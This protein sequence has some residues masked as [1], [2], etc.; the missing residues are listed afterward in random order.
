MAEAKRVDFNA[1]PREVRERLI[2]CMQH[3]SYP[4]PLLS[5]VTSQ[6]AAIA[7]WVILALVGGLIVLVPLAADFGRKLQD[8]A[9]IAAYALGVA[10]VLLS[11]LF[12]ARRVML[13]NALPYKPG[14]FLFPMDFIDATDRNLRVVPMSAL[15]DFRGVHQ[16]TNG[17]Y[18][19]T[20]LT[21][22]FEGGIRES[23]VIQ[24][25]D[26]AEEVL[27]QLQNSQRAIR[28]AAQ[29]RDLDTLLR[30]DPF[31]EVRVKDTWGAQAPRDEDVSGPVAKRLPGLLASAAPIL[32]VS[33]V[34]ALVISIPMWHLRNVASDEAMFAN[35]KRLDSSYEY[36]HYVEYGKRHLDE[37]RDDLLPRAALREAKQ[38]G[39]VTALRTF[40]HDYPKS[41]VEKDARDEI[42]ALF[43]K[44]LGDYREQAATQDPKLLPF[45]EKLLAYLEKNETARVEA[46]FESPST[47]ALQKTD[48]LL[49]T[50]L[51][52]ELAGGG[53]I[54][55]VAPHFADK[56]S[57]PRE[58]EIVT[59]LQK[60]FGE[61]F[62][63]DVMAL[64]QGPRIGPD[65]KPLPGQA[66]DSGSSSPKRNPLLDVDYKDPQALAR[67]LAA[68]RTGSSDEEASDPNDD[69][70][71]AA[72][73]T[74]E[75]KYKVAW[76]GD[77]YTEEK[78]DRKFVGI[79]VDFHVAMKIPGESDT[80]EF[81]LAVKPP[82]RFTVNYTQYNDIGDTGPSEGQVYDQMAERAFDQLSERM[83]KVFF[84]PG[85]KAYGPPDPV[86]PGLGEGDEGDAPLPG[87]GGKKP[88]G[89]LGA[90]GRKPNKL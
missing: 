31:F 34:A 49:Q 40:L 39:S 11:G 51:G 55:P 46:R 16:H 41:V 1:L 3:T 4:Y 73:P 52:N 70:T 56:L 7:G 78:G 76:A 63:T 18:T 17:V 38:K 54:I 25:K 43:T 80:V 13:G 87:V 71:K 75:I 89:G 74:L 29:A 2:A 47:E 57:L 65:G 32:G 64:K 90:G 72:P 69:G 84:R 85:S 68:S 36:K 42:H 83:K 19:G 44:E 12:L 37:V 30:M 8:P 33:A 67:A 88:G 58:R 24:G 10:V 21:F 28:E 53:H 59:G 79:V 81:D 60:G 62:P 86:E 26:R 20:T 66:A 23:F 14:R 45:M 61:V 27:R 22:T 6:G 77:I 50:K 15:V 5:A 82:D 48:E 35:A 9:M